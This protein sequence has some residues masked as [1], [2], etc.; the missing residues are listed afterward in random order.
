MIAVVS[1]LEQEIRDFKR[2]MAVRRMSSYQC[3]RIYEG[4]IRDTECLLVLTGVGR[5]HAS[6]VTQLIFATYPVRALISTGFCGSLNDKIDAGDIM[7]YTGLCDGDGVEVGPPP[8]LLMSEAGLVEMALRISGGSGSQ[9]VGARG[10]TLSSV[11]AAPEDKYRLGT[12][13]SAAAVDMESYSIG[14]VAL[15]RNCPFIAARVVLDTVQ[16]DLRIL[17]NLGAGGKLLASRFLT[18]LI[19]HPSGARNLIGLSLKS[20]KATKRLG[21]F[22]SRLVESMPC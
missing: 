12:Q 22:L 10:V 9:T 7:V 1:A 8:G 13:H 19:V 20:K 16:D 17:D 21:M 5:K 15:E 18:H 11:C 3:C 2:R 4:K 6:E 14:Q